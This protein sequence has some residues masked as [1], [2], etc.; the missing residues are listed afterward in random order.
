MSADSV[1]YAGKCGA[2]IPAN[3]LTQACIA[4]PDPA[5]RVWLL[6]NGSP[7]LQLALLCGSKTTVRVLATNETSIQHDS[8]VPA[9]VA[10]LPDTPRVLAREVLLQSEAGHTH[11]YAISWW[12]LAQAKMYLENSDTPIWTQLTSVHAG[13]H[14][15]VH[16]TCVALHVPLGTCPM[17]P[18]P[19]PDSH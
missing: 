9:Y 2:S 11:G 17:Q 12:P 14:R 3:D 1:L 16:G 5:L 10:E 4:I 7:T 15:E 19:H 8:D 18:C 13:L 6:G